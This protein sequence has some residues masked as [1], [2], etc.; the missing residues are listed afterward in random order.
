MTMMTIW[1]CWKETFLELLCNF[2]FVKHCQL[3]SE[4]VWTTNSRQ[5]EVRQQQKTKTCM[6][7]FSNVRKWHLQR[8]SWGHNNNKNKKSILFSNFVLKFSMYT[9]KWLCFEIRV[10]T[11]YFVDHSIVDNLKRNEHVHNIHYMYM[12]K[13]NLD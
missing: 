13:Y 11:T 8:Y 7:S 1:K 4:R 12:Y 5:H 10:T 2:I 9:A 3:Q 6:G